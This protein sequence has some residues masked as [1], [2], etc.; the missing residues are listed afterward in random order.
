MCRD[1]LLVLCKE[2]GSED[3]YD[4]P[5]VTQLVCDGTGVRTQACSA[6]KLTDCT[7]E[8]RFQKLNMGCNRDVKKDAIL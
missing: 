3:L 6:R 8:S 7:K 5:A 1:T 4:W 2:M